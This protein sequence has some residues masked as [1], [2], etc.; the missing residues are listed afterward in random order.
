[1]K[2]IWII[3]GPNLNLLGTREPGIYG[4]LT[5]EEINRRIAREAE[6]L[7][8]RVAFFQSNREGELVDRLHAAAGAADGVVLNAG[9][10]THTSVALADAVSG[11]GLRVIEVHL[12]NVHRREAFRRHSFLSPVCEGVICGLGWKGYVLALRALLTEE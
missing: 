10:Y 11:T 5:L 12:S 9:A 4:A 6:A 2:T 3:N 1:M 8:V 7:G